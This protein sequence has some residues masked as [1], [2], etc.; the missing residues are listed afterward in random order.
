[1]SQTSV[2]LLRY[3]EGVTFLCAEASL[4]PRASTDPIPK[5]RLLFSIC[6]EHAE[7]KWSVS[8][9][10][11][12]T[13]P[14]ALQEKA[15][16]AAGKQQWEWTGGCLPGALQPLPDSWSCDVM[17]IKVSNSGTD[18]FSPERSVQISIHTVS[19]CHGLLL[20]SCPPCPHP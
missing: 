17:N 12:F 11:C 13:R 6:A 7:L 15:S 4:N 10:A 5:V 19:A 2:C 18:H 8:E 1:M 20:Q 16:T 9:S 14:R 3:N